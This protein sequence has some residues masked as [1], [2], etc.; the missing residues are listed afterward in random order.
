MPQPTTAETVV[1]C[2]QLA[3]SIGDPA[4]NRSITLE[5]ITRAANAGAQVVVLPELASSGYAFADAEE[6]RTCAE[7]VDG[8]SVTAWRAAARQHDLVIIAGLCEL[9]RDGQV[10]NSAVVVDPSGLRAVYRKAHL[11]DNER[12]IFVAGD[13]APPV[14]DTKHGRIAVMVCYDLEFPEWVR[15][16]ALS[17]AQLI[18]VPTNWPASAHPMGER[19]GEVIRAQAAAGANRVFIAACDRVGAERGVDWLGAS[20]I[21]DPDGYP[22]SGP[23]TAHDETMLLARCVLADAD[24]KGVGTMSDVLADRRVDLYQAHLDS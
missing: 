15:V 1:A 4:A 3:P 11:W 10:R 20:V 7:P 18:C 2:C 12:T 16:P 9:D 23:A 8:P 24:R 5:A 13:A 19:P 17:G 21:L 22:L 6:A 14:I